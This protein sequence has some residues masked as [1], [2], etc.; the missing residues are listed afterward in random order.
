M[1]DV[2][3]ST[4]G[5]SLVY[6]GSDVWVNKWLKEVSPK[7]TY[8]SKLLIHRNRIDDLN[9]EFDTDVEVV[10]QSD[11]PIK[12]EQYIKEC[13]RINI[14]HGY[15]TPHKLI[16]EH[17]DKIHSNVVHVSLDLSLQAGFTLNLPRLMHFASSKEWERDVLKWSKHKIWIGVQKTP[18][19]KDFD[20]IDIPNYYEFERNKD[21]VMN[22]TIGFAARMETRKAPHFLLGHKSFAFTDIFDVQEWE[23][24]L[25][26]KF[27][28]TRFYQFK[29]Q[30]LKRFLDRDDWGISHSAH[31]N[32]PFG[33][34]IFE[35]IDYGK[36]PILPHN[37]CDDMHYPFRA[38]TKEE[39]DKCVEEIKT[40]SES[41][42]KIL[43]EGLRKN[44]KKYDNK[45]E[46]VEKYLRIYNE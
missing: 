12:F 24:K 39:F 15:Y 14:L 7:L 25:K 21:I 35:A 38:T 6:G 31:L 5:G 9:V 29:Y 13:R 28:D 34:S 43:L 46:W 17:R 42:R 37:W 18:L 11:D 22:D 40:L 23:R 30:F 44:L 27:S 45:E 32:E 19:H 33:Y 1:F 16:S 4:G 20:L 3:Y 10:W 36:L 26:I 2:Y 41:H 8:P